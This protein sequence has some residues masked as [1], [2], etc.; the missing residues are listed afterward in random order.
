VEVRG[1]ELY[2]RDAD[3]KHVPWKPPVADTVSF[4]EK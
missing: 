1:K 3:G 2:R 4:R